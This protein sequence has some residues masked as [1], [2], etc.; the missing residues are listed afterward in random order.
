MNERGIKITL[1]VGEL[2]WTNFMYYRE[3]KEMIEKILNSNVDKKV[4]LEELLNNFDCG[5]VYDSKDEIVTDAF[6]TLKH[7][8][9]NEE[10]IT[11]EEWGYFLE[12]LD[13]KRVYNMKEKLCILCKK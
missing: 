8:A 13:G 11:L 2:S 5:E 3:L 4:L 7:Y 9:C 10:N 12:C 1:K 6:L